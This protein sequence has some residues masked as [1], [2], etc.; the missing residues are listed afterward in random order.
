LLQGP[1]NTFG[2]LPRHVQL[3]R[4]DIT[5]VCHFRAL[6]CAPAPFCTLPLKLERHREA[7]HGLT[8]AFRTIGSVF[9][10]YFLVFPVRRSIPARNFDPLRGACRNFSP[11]NP[12]DCAPSLSVC[13]YS[14]GRHLIYSVFERPVWLKG[15]L[16]DIYP[17]GSLLIPW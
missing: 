9:K 7:H 6:S 8:V 2:T 5:V 16:A 14:V 4:V 10:I 1:R 15:S 17:Q 12:S 3:Q 13:N 11:G